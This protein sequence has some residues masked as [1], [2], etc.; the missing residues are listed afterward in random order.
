MKQLVVEKNNPIPILWDTPIPQPGPGEVLIRNHY[1]VISSGTEL[2]TIE[3]SNKSVAEKFQNKSN[4]EKGLHLLKTNGIAA[5]WNAVFPRNILPIKLG[6]SSA[7]EV[8][9][10]GQ[11]SSPMISGFSECSITAAAISG[12]SSPCAKA[13][14]QPTI[15]LSVSTSISVADLAATHP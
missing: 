7:G 4:L 3:N 9:Q 10:L 12:A 15:P 8:V 5:V 13:S 2:A 11:G 14:P 6:Y 1:S